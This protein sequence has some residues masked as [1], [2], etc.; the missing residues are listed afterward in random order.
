MKPKWILALAVTSVVAL[1]QTNVVT[2]SPPQVELIDRLDVI[3]T[4]VAAIIGLF[5]K[6]LHSTSRKNST[7]AEIMIRAIEE[8]DNPKVKA[9]IAVLAEREGFTEFI[10]KKVKTVTEEPPSDSS[11]SN[12]KN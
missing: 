3:L 8:A 5:A 4:A 2:T 9:A 10:H 11:T 1:A 6:I 12:P 7:A